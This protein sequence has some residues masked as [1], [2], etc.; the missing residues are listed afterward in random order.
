[1]VEA[2]LMSGVHK[3]VHIDGVTNTGGSG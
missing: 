2:V 3:K 1:M